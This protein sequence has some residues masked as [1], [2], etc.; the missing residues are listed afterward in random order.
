MS[1]R[2]RYEAQGTRFLISD[3]DLNDRSRRIKAVLFDW[4]GVFNDGFKDLDGG[5]PFSEVDSMGVNL[6]R[7][8]I[9]TRNGEV[10]PVAAI[11]T[12][13]HNKFAERYAERER[14]HGV[15]MGFTNKP[16]AFNE[17]L[18]EHGLKAEEVAFVFDDVLDLPVAEHC[19]LRVVIGHQATQEF[20]AS[21]VKRKSADV[22]VPSG[23]GRHPLREACELLMALWGCWDD[24]VDHRVKYSDTYQRY[25][26]ARNAIQPKAVR[27][28][29]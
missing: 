8:A 26:A 17:L 28:T 21:A 25:L 3:A 4:D 15:Y 2:A 22:I 20:Q 11:I 9:W 5:S 16:E 6:L 7:F 18:N 24:V 10:L 14:F 13:Q 19:G 29:R 1:V 27:N 12:G 23:N